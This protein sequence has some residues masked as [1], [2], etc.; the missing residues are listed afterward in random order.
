MSRVRD[1]RLEVEDSDVTDDVTVALTGGSHL[2]VAARE[3]KEGR[4]RLGLHG[5]LLAGLAQ[6]SAGL[7]LFYFF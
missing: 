3:K 2:S 5:L 6:V 7:G 4:A 1:L